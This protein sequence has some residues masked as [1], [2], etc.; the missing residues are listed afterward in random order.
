ML[1]I[2][3]S[4]SPLLREPCQ[5]I[6]E[7][8]P[9][10]RALATEMIET[11]YASHGVGIA[12]PQVGKLVRMIVVDVDYTDEASKDPLVLIN[13]VVEWGS[14]ETEEGDEGCLSIPG[15][16]FPIVRHKEIRVSAQ[17]LDGD[18]IEIEAGND[19]F[20]RCLQ[21]EIDHIN[22]VTMFERLRPQD[23]VKATALYREACMR[24]AKPGEID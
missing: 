5:E 1:E 3:T 21:H 6:T 20:G 19:L 23:R 24:G 15:V 12:A 14:E 11:M 4:P 16:S 13:P 18:T 8:T 17:D 10:I 7:I 2:V 22:G 9:E